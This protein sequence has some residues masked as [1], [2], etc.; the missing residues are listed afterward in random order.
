MEKDGLIRVVG[1]GIAGVLVAWEL[2]KRGR[3]VC[4]VDDGRPGR[5]SAVAA[6]LLNPVT[7][8]R[9]RLADPERRLLPTAIATFSE[10]ATATGER[11]FHPLPIFREFRDDREREAWEK[12]S[13]DPGVARFVARN[14]REGIT[15][16]GGGWVDYRALGRL[17]AR[18]GIPQT[19]E[20]VPTAGGHRDREIT[21]TVYCTGHSP[22]LFPEL[23]WLPA[24]GDLMTVRLPGWDGSA[25]RLRGLFTVPLG[26]ER[27]RV[28]A[29]YVWENLDPAPHE[30]RRR[31]LLGQ[32]R[33]WTG[34]EPTVER[35]EV[36]IRPAL[37]TRQPVFGPIGEREFLLNGL[38][39]K[40][41][42]W[43]PWAA[44]E[45]VRMIFGEREPIPEFLP[46]KPSQRLTAWA[47][48]VIRAYLPGGGVAVDATAGN[49][50]DTLFLAERV[51]PRGRVEAFDLQSE[52]TEATRRRLVTAGMDSR[53]R[54]HE[55]DH[56]EAARMVGPV[57]GGRVHAV[58]MN[59]GYLPGGD[60]SLT[61]RPQSTLQCLDGLVPLMAKRAAIVVVAYRGHAGGS[62][63][64]AGVASWMQARSAEG[65]R[66]FRRPSSS[67]EGPEGFALLR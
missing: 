7:G 24:A 37:Q 8:K 61:T 16:Q 59:L 32:L 1:G 15:F 44:A 27:F 21:A 42:L 60:E 43:A 18:L 53:V 12:R 41:S 63:E 35:H 49:G 29:T 55:A 34:I 3:A 40:G 57:P 65:W 2:R 38:G 11:L 48:A 20:S 28:G 9:F 31:E 5:A 25:I 36:G 51:G 10:L 22:E 64:H 54:L 23:P 33:D 6:G 13:G 62:R 30:E 47:Q 67:P 46:P 14:D 56:A 52:A 66:L 17:P 4:L 45:L 58:M 19:R 50:C 26:G 39:S